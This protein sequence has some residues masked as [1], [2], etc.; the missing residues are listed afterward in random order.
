[1]QQSTLKLISQQFYNMNIYGGKM[2]GEEY[3][4]KVYDGSLGRYCGGFAKEI[5]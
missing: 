1:M 4:L 5:I 3:R 2:Q